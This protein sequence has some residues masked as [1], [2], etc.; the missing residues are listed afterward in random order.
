V[1]V[2]QTIER[3]LTARFAPVRLEVVDES[4]RHEGHA[5][6]QPGG[7]THYHVTLVSAVFTGMSR[8]ARQRL[9]YEALAD[10]LRSGV[11]ALALATL[12]PDE[13]CK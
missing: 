4:H 2:A 13:E 5:G 7:E 9:V 12:A 8:V 11:H 10:E 3:K 1:T 6:A